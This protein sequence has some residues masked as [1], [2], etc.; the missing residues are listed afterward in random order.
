MTHSELDKWR[1]YVPFAIFGL[2]ILPWFLVRYKT[3]AEV[4]L[5]NELIAPILAVILAFFYVGFDFRRPHWRSEIEAHVGKQIREAVLDMVP[6]DLAVTE[7]EKRDLR[8][9]VFKELTGVFWEAIDQ[10]DALRSQKEH[11]YSNGIVYST[12][13]D[14]YLI[15]GF[16]GFIYAGMSLLAKEVTFAYVGMALIV[17]AVGSRIFVTPRRRAIHLA[18]SREQLDFLRRQK[19]DFVANRFREIVTGWRKR[20]VLHA[21]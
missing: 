16:F 13:I 17:L 2:C 21:G 3:L 14:V 6:K 19:A 18:L 12:S 15:C 8:G 11:F 9:E 7:R 5:A 20:R 1:K 4:K 10:S